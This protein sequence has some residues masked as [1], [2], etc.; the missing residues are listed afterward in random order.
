AREAVAAYYAR[1]GQAVDPARVWLCASTSEAY[2]HLLT[3]LADPGDAVLVPHPGYPLLDML[4]DLAGVR[5]VPYPLGLHGA[6]AI[7]TDGLRRA[8]RAE[9]RARV[10]LVVAP[11]NPTGA[12]LDPGQWNALHE[13]AAEHGLAVVV[14]EVFADY[15]LDPPPDR[16][17]FVG[18]P[19]RPCVVLSGLSKVAALP[20]LKLSWVVLHGPSPV[21]D[22]LLARAELVADTFLSVNTPVQLALPALLD[23]AERM[24]PRIRARLRANLRQLRARVRDQ[25]VDLLPVDA[26][27]TALLRLPA[28]HELDDL[29]W[30]RRLLA[31]GVLVQPGFLFDLP[32]PPRVAVSLL[33]P[34]DALDSGV[35]RLLEVVGATVAADHLA[36]I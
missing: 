18:D 8:L 14:D 2:A 16:L 23:A 21:I 7:D 25:P 30:A 36:P 35:R 33:T 3:L 26:G 34:E 4:G 19:A 11:H 5:R 13:L 12:M 20:Q 9:P 22:P 31:G 15:P 6:W 28:V 27:F 17:R 10:L 32:A 24:Q 1:R 29:G